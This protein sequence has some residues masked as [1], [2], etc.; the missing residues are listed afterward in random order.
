MRK[1]ILLFTPVAGKYLINV[2]IG[3]DAIRR[4]GLIQVLPKWKN[5]KKFQ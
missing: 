2:K 1:E 5:N 4:L 3:G